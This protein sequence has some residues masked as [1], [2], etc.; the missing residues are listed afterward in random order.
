MKY[1]TSHFIIILL[2]HI[3]GLAQMNSTYLHKLNI[4]GIPFNKKT[5]VVFEDHLGFLWLGTDSGL[6]RY[7]GHS[8]VEHQYDV[9]N[10]HSI[11]NNSINSIVEDDLGNLWIGSESYLICYT[12]KSNKFIGYYKNNTSKVLGKSSDGIIWANLWN[13]GVVKI[14]PDEN[15]EHI[16]FQTDFNYKQDN[17]IWA[18]DRQI[19]QVS[20]DHYGRIWLATPNGILHFGDNG[21]LIETGFNENT[22][23]LTRIKNNTFIACTDEGLYILGYGKDHNRLEILE[24]YT[25][26]PCKSF[27]LNEFTAIVQEDGA[28]TLW[29]GTQ[30]GLIKGVRKNNK[31]AF[32]N[33]NNPNIQ[34][35]PSE[36]RINSLELDRYNNLWIATNKGVIKYIGRT[37]IFEYTGIG[38]DLT[39]F[40][41]QTLIKENSREMLLTI[42]QKGLYRYHK[43]RRTNTLLLATDENSSYIKK[44]YQN[45]ELLIGFGRFLLKTKNYNQKK[46]LL[47]VDTIQKF[48][49]DIK[50]IIPLNKNEIWVGLWGGGIKIVNTETDISDF[51][52]KTMLHFLGMNVS[53]MHLDKLQNIWIGTRGDGLFKVDLNNE[54]IKTFNPSVNDGLSSNAIL[55]LLETGQ[56]NMWIGTRGGG[57]N[58]YDSQYQTIKSFGKKEGLLSTTISSIEMDKSG[59]LWLSTHGGISRFNIANEK[60]VNFGIEDGL[61]ESHFI[62]NSHTADEDGTLYFGCPGGFYTVN[63]KNFKKSYQLPNTIITNFTI[64]GDKNKKIDT[65]QFPS[66]V[67]PTNTINKIELPYNYNNIAIEF[68]SL[69]FTAPN[70]NEYAYMLE[71]INDTWHYTKASNRNANYNDLSPGAYTFK[72][73]SSNSDGVWNETPTIVQFEITPPFWRQTTAH[74]IYGIL[75]MITVF[76]C[77]Y[78]IKRWYKLKKNLVAETISR[79]KDNEHNR[80][81]MI[82]FTDI[83]HELR[84]PLSLISGTIEKVVKEKNFALSPL[85]AQRIYNNTLR[86]QRLINQI[87][88]IRKFDVGKFNLSIS[89][90]DIVKDISIIKDS[91]NDFA[92]IYEIQYDFICNEPIIKGWYD[93]DILEKMLFNLLSNAFKF[94][95]EKGVIRVSL[96][97]ATKEDPKANSLDLD[98]NTYIKCAVRDNGMGIPKKDLPYIFDRYY[99][100]TKSYSNQI[101]GTGVGMELVHKLI[102]RHQGLIM[103][104]SEENVFTEFTFYLPI[105][106]SKYPKS[107]RLKQ[108]MPLKRKFIQNSEYQVI[109]EVS[110]E[111]ESKQNTKKSTKQTILLVEDNEDLRTM[112]KEELTTDFNVMEASNGKVGYEMVLKEM[113]SL[114]ISDILM[115]IEDGITMLERIKKKDETNNI[116]I[117]MLT[118]KHAEET[119]IK[120]LSLGADD[121]IEKPFSLEFV[122]WKVKN[123]L[124]TRKELKEKYSKIITPEPSEIEIDSNDEKFIK[125]LIMIIEESMTDNLLS[126]EYLASEIGMSR[127][128]LYRKIKAIAN[129]TPVNFIKKIK[130]KRAAQ[131]LKT[132]NMYIS[133]VAYM[134][135]FNNQKYFGKC[136]QKEYQMSPTEYIKKHTSRKEEVLI[137]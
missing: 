90:N 11:P 114:I 64:L 13:T 95:K 61:A 39:N 130:L 116:P 134:T 17:N 43:K 76:I 122:K 94:T 126:V 42:N 18:N 62:F 86:M 2:F 82:F 79:E 24:T 31:Y 35:V 98:K 136:F 72:V 127:A 105:N 57:L 109:Q 14:I 101:P 10:K 83:S 103:V 84:T 121:Y 40:F 8:I 60:F 137:D 131:L 75:L 1:P 32:V 28:A 47:E 22:Q 70:K 81:K 113:P 53:V 3:A 125:K 66:E 128:N 54:E 5:N 129:D 29:I 132:N 52:S 27:L 118:A 106:K 92:R 49:K 115:P 36:R 91:F 56:G 12:R 51:K 133:E 26:F 25:D 33:I 48:T 23:I 124:G 34:N 4:E 46:G 87:M 111:F 102:V 55:S 20:E 19:N 99:Q 69:D 50:D 71:G 96:E 16:E 45:E 73:I 37:P 58:Y 41:P 108:G 104:D 100:A 9:F 21:T 59:N 123:A 38:D 107:E 85:T 110:S 68:S 74:I 67:L 78:L 112:I 80:M 63:A 7:D 135:G 65:G 30:F 117:F 15:P 97:I 77:T 44:D 119:K 120:C 89:K 88:D 6:Y 93:V